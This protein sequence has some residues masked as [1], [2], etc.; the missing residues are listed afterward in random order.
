MFGIIAK[1]QKDDEVKEYVFAFSVIISE[2]R[3]TETIICSS[4]LDDLCNCVQ[5]Q[6]ECNKKGPLRFYDCLMTWND[7]FHLAVSKE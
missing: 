7:N 2:F 6:V 1:I 3:D 5:R 4:S